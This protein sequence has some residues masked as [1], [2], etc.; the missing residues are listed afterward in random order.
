[1]S[2]REKN[3]PHQGKLISSADP[4]QDQLL[5][6][7]TEEQ[8]L[9]G[10]LLLSSRFRNNFSHQICF[11]KDGLQVRLQLLKQDVKLLDKLQNMAISF[12]MVKN[13]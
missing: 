2:G 1:M 8:H 3:A 12:L 7:G 13:S 10:Q 9:A 4:R 11:R 6:P 5:A